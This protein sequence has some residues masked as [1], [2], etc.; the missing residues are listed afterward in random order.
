MDSTKRIL[1]IELGD[2]RDRHREVMTDEVSKPREHHDSGKPAVVEGVLREVTVA[3]LSTA[4]HR[5]GMKGTKDYRIAAL[6]RNSPSI[7]SFWHGMCLLSTQ[8]SREKIPSRIYL[9]N[10]T[11][12]RSFFIE[13]AHDN[14][15]RR[16]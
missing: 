7:R 14:I 5:T 9:N 1:E 8:S 11:S 12:S 10:E 2:T 3:P 16:V 15:S 6:D 4:L 13:S